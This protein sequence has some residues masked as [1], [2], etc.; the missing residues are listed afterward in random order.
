MARRLIACPLVDRDGVRRRKEVP[1]EVIDT[2]RRRP[3]AV[4]GGQA[5]GYRVPASGAD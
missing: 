1:A 2:V 5:R 3:P 4:R